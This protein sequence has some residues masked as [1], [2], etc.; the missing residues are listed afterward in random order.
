MALRIACLT[1]V[2][3]DC[4]KLGRFWAATL[5]W[6][7]VEVTEESIFLVPQEESA[8]TIRSPDCSFFGLGATRSPRIGCT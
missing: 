6:E 1:I 5:D 3:E 4:Q 2:A 7:M 8:R